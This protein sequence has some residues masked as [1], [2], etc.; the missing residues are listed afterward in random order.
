MLEWNEIELNKDTWMHA[1]W[2]FINCCSHFK[3]IHWYW[4]YTGFTKS[5]YQWWSIDYLG[6]SQWWTPMVRTHKCHYVYRPLKMAK[7]R[8]ERWSHRIQTQGLWLS[9]PVLC[10]CTPL[11]TKRTL[12]KVVAI[13]GYWWR[14][15]EERDVHAYI[16]WYISCR[17]GNCIYKQVYIMCVC[18]CLCVCTHVSVY[19]CACD[20]THFHRTLQCTLEYRHN[21]KYWD[22]VFHHS[23][24][25][26]SHKLLVWWRTGH[27]NVS[28]V[29][30]ALLQ[31]ARSVV[32]P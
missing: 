4:Q 17:H 12:R 22:P 29:T 10:H 11:T 19:V 9:V 1:E 30:Q 8:K 28:K 2:P 24:T 25:S 13:D 31:C 32:H 15:S 7:G 5:G 21:G 23:G 18:V 3:L 27:K 20:Q 14:R 26:L 6:I 16:L